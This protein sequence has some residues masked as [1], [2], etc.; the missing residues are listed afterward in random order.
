MSIVIVVL[1]G[2]YTG[3]F[4]P[5][6][7]A[8]F[9]CLVAFILGKF[10]YRKIHWRDIPGIL[11]RTVRV[12]GTCSAIFAAAACFSY[13]ITL[14]NVPK[15]FAEFLLG[16]SANR[17]VML[18][19]VNV[20]VL[21]VGCFMEGLSIIL[22]ITPLILPM[23]LSLGI[24]PVHVGVILAINTTLGLLTPPLGLS[25]FMASSI[26]KTPVL[27]IAKKAMPMFIALVAILLLITYVPGIT[28]FLPG[29]ILK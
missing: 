17:Y 4:T 20:I 27:E 9:A 6:E 12:L 14:E 7:A 5:T 10:V 26:T 22:I 29:L 18:L 8:G 3:F 21:F 28:L 15:I 2:I 1:G 13:V 25:L 24:D 19:L 11:A 16:F 23:L